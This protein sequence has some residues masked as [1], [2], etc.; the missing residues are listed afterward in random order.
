M[1]LKKCNDEL[2]AEI[3][4]TR[5]WYNDLINRLLDEEEKINRMLN[6]VVKDIKDNQ[7]KKD[8][9]DIMNGE[10]DKKENDPGK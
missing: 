5:D 8:V 9:L 7:V 6:R 2:K 3:R 4:A 10:K 1:Y